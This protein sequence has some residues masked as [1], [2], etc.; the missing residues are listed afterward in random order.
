[1]FF[2]P[3]IFSKQFNGTDITLNEPQIRLLKA[4]NGKWNFS[5][6]GKASA[7]KQPSTSGS[8]APLA[9]QKHIVV[10]SRKGDHTRSGDLVF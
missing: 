5:S 1:L 9:R 7:K 6:L 8:G 4:A 2:W 10:C 3:L